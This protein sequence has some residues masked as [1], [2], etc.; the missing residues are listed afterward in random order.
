MREPR[1]ITLEDYLFEKGVG[2]P[3]SD[4]MIDK[5]KIPHGL[6]K[7][8]KEKLTSDAMREARDYQA[9][10]RKSIEEYNEKVRNGEIQD[11]TNFEKTLRTAGGHPDN[12]STQAA[13]RMLKKRYG[14]D[15]KKRP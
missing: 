12:A 6:T 10:R 9:E 4:Y 2:F 13:R 11:L 15:Y 8:Q 7:R 1:K 3:V 5:S 14:I